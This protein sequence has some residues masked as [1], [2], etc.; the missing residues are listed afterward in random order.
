VAIEAWPIMFLRCCFRGGV[1]ALLI[2]VGTT[3]ASGAA[4]R[5]DDIWLAPT[6]KLQDGFEQRAKIVP[7][8][9]ADAL[10]LIRVA[11]RKGEPRHM[12]G[13]PPEPKKPVEPVTP[14]AKPPQAAQPPP[15]P[16]VPKAPVAA[17]QQGREEA[18]ER[19]RKRGAPAN[20]APQLPVVP[21]QPVARA[22]P[23]AAQARQRAENEIEKQVRRERQEAERRLGERER[24]ETERRRAQHEQEEAVRRQANREQQELGRR[25]ER[26]EREARVAEKERPQG[27]KQAEPAR[28]PHRAEKREEHKRAEKREENKEQRGEKREEHKHAEKREEHKQKQVEKREEQEQR[29]AE[30]REELAERLKRREA[31]RERKIAEAAAKKAA[32]EAKKAAEEAAKKAAEEAAKKVAEA[33][34]KKA[35]EEAAARKRAEEEKAREIARKLAEKLPIAAPAVPVQA[36]EVKQVIQEVV[37]EVTK[38]VEAVAAAPSQP[39]GGPFEGA[40]M[41]AGI[42]VEK[43]TAEAKLPRKL[44]EEVQAKRPGAGGGAVRLGGLGRLPP[45]PETYKAGELFLPSPSTALLTEL[46]RLGY[47][48]GEATPSGN[49]RVLLPPGAPQAWEVQRELEAKFPGESVGLNFVYKPYHGAT[50]ESA[51]PKPVTPGPGVGCSDD[52]CYGRGLIAWRNELA[53]CAAG[54][55]IGLIDTMVDKRHPAFAHTKLEVHSVAFKQDAPAARHWHGTGV[56]AVM[57][58][59]TDSRV[60]GLI[61]DARYVAVNAFFTNNKGELETDTAHLTE[62]LDF[63]DKAGVRII[64]MS[65]VGPSDDLVHDRITDMAR[66]GVVFVAAAGNGGPDAAAGYP[67]AYEEVIAVTAVDRKRGSYDSANRGDYIDVAAPG[68]QILT[69]L[70]D[71]QHGLLTGTSFAAPFVTSVVAVAYEDTRRARE[72]RSGGGQQTPK[73]MML[74]QLFGKDEL[75]KRDRVYGHGVIK[76]P[77]SCGKQLW[78]AAVAPT[79]PAVAPAAIPAASGGWPALIRPSSLFGSR[80]P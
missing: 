9:N 67:A 63:L 43:E 14:P 54:V 37:K 57:A 77:A 22:E 64:N 34:A 42:P 33:A 32:E 5:D 21:P 15:A 46:R 20:A 18:R 80:Q 65:I 31:E 59:G 40:I 2:G 74:S 56:L 50:K 4:G 12:P 55:S 1:A 71:G 72:A 17:N 41:R 6:L 51:Y 68:V 75:A 35:A 61:P 79:G 60:P 52:K 73:A 27:E 11:G 29:R 3:V 8:A 36:P 49:V 69:A 19:N 25:A 10:P 38:T 78:S 44:T 45:T 53:A 66:R 47:P 30:K 58:G 76:A 24:Q 48:F 70:P 26:R 16:P 39:E 23:P 28:A 7:N 13:P 62:A